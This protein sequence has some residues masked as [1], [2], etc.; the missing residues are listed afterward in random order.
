MERDTK[1]CGGSM[2]RIETTIGELVC[3]IADAAEEATNNEMELQKL[4]HLILM[5]L[6]HNYQQ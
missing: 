4:T 2:E 3:A 5:R 6:L 1:V